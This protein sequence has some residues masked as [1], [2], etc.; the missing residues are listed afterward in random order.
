[1]LKRSI[2]PEKTLFIPTASF[3]DACGWFV[4]SEFILELGFPYLLAH[5]LGVPVP[6]AK[7][8]ITITEGGIY[9]LYA[10]T[11]NWVAP[12]HPDIPGSDGH[13]KNR[14]GLRKEQASRL[15]RRD[16]CGPCA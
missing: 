11:Y 9:H 3:D 1:M 13:Q 7:K 12:W 15:R 5:G 6:D 10:Y 4:D 14:G 8:T 16:G 2:L